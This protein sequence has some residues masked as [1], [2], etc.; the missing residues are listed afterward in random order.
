M[1]GFASRDLVE[2]GRLDIARQS[3]N[4][5]VTG[6]ARAGI[7]G[8]PVDVEA[9]MPSQRLTGAIAAVSV[10]A[11]TVSLEAIAEEA[12]PWATAHGRIVVELD[13]HECSASALSADTQG[14][15]KAA[16]GPGRIE[17]GSCIT[18]RIAS[19]AA[20]RLSLLSRDAQGRATQIL[21]NKY[22]SGLFRQV[23]KLNP[24]QATAVPAP[25]D[26][27]EL[28]VVGSPKPETGVSPGRSEVI[29]IVTPEGA[30]AQELAARLEGRLPL[31]DG[32]G[33]VFEIRVA[34]LSPNAD[35]CK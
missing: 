3:D 34:P 1:Q 26:D 33:A 10:F 13:A 27:F 2:P 29:A 32:E 5:V 9:R 23:V 19:D 11:L 25:G 28:R 12:A 35:G 4:V 8:K 18:L 30:K 22:N 6:T 7:L 24:G 15:A 16:N 20:G 31:V 21:P 14:Q 17:A